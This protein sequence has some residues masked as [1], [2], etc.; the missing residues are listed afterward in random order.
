MLPPSQ[1]K[2]KEKDN[3]GKE[4]PESKEIVSIEKDKGKSEDKDKQNI[5]NK[6]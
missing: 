1:E 3:E 5:L 4:E 6:D 2:I